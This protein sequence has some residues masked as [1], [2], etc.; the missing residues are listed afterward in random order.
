MAAVSVAS[1]GAPAPA[2]PAGFTV[3]LRDDVRR[4]DR[5][6]VLLGGSPPRVVR[7]ARP[8]DAGGLVV[9]TDASTERFARRLLEG[10]LAD[11]V[12]GPP[13]AARDLTVVIPVRDRPGQLD[14]CLRALAG[15]PV[16]VID[17]ASLDRPAV[18]AV[19][20]RHGA[21]LLPLP[22]NVGPASARNV[23]L[24]AVRTP[25]VAFVDSDVEAPALMLRRLAAHLD[26]PAVALAA[27]LVRAVARS[28]RPRWWER[29]DAAASSLTLGRRACSVRPG[30]AVAWLPSAC[31]VGRVAALREVGGFSEGMRV[32]EDV[33]LVW[34]L[35]GDGRTVRYDPEHEA[36][37][38]VRGTIRGW[39]GRKAVYGSG[40]GDLA[41][42]H[43]D[44]VA[45]AV[46]GRAMGLAALGVLL[47]R[48]WSLP[49][50]AAVTLRGAWSVRRLLPEVPG[51]EAQAARLAVQGM[52]WAL[53]Q[54]SALV[55][56][57]WWPGVAVAAIVS[58][59]ARRVVA[60]ALVADAIVQL[61]VDR[62]QV[63]PLAGWAGRRLDD[64]AYGGGLWLGAIRAR[65]ARCLAPRITRF[66]RRTHL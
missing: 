57:H 17:D 33:D 58:R 3:R 63:P 12:L 42:R 41:A 64:L 55:L 18:A 9:V 51:R 49:L 24:A 19:V 31:L 15:L 54:E 61:A 45:P 23:G 30:A 5:G 7:L 43:G 4:L 37:H 10:N 32:G 28:A 34:R 13:A 47:R 21:R 27:P 25:L 52:G 65:S 39:L 46:L 20:A 59:R 56:R 2:L 26:D 53:R 38:D 11:P 40:G 48:P 35:V 14:Q 1:A 6:R 62:P 66:G 29:Y 50:A 36:M 44:A 22:V 8:L 16:L 60:S